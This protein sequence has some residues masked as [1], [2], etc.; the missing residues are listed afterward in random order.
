[1]IDSNPPT[2]QAMLHR[3]G[4]LLR[5]VLKHGTID[6]IS[7]EEELAFIRAY[8]DLEHMRLGSRLTVRW[9]IAPDS[10]NALIPQLLLQPLVENAIVHGIAPAREG[11]WIAIDASVRDDVLFVEIRNSVVAAPQPGLRV[12]LENVRAR[13]KHLYADDAHFEFVV[14]GEA[15]VAVARLRIPAFVDPIPIVDV[16]SSLA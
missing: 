8:L 11:G 12:G 4:S 13:L 9:C 1:L 7:L 16:E 10:T 2:A 6:L 3:L 14:Q 5:T 15:S